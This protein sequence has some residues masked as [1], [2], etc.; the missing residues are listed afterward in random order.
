M[1]LHI[2]FPSPVGVRPLTQLLP[3]VKLQEEEL[4]ARFRPLLG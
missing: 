4:D 3:V 2:S 1:L